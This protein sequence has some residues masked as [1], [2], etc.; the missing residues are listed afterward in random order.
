MG[1]TGNYEGNKQNEEQ[2]VLYVEFMVLRFSSSGVQKETNEVRM[3][4][5]SVL[6][7]YSSGWSSG[8]T[9]GTD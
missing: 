8:D 7:Y 5:I 1:K 6:F 2:H 3:I 9:E 4:N